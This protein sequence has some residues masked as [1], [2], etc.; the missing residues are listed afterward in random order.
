MYNVH[1]GSGGGAA[2]VYNVHSESGGG[3][4]HDGRTCDGALF[5]GLLGSQSTFIHTVAY[6]YKLLVFLM[7]I[8]FSRLYNIVQE[9]IQ[10]AQMICKKIFLYWPIN[11]L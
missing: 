5:V 11:L 8:L 7:F 1:P 2:P 6:F 9:K 10:I 3:T 4:S